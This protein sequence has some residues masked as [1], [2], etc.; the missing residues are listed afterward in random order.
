MYTCRILRIPFCVLS[1]LL[2]FCKL[3]DRHLIEVRGHIGS[4]FCLAYHA[5]HTLIV[6]CLF[7]NSV[8][9]VFTQ[10]T[11]VGTP[12]RT[13]STCKSSKIR[14]MLLQVNGC[15]TAK[16]KAIVLY[17][18]Q[19]AIDEADYS[20]GAPSVPRQLDHQSMRKTGY[21]DLIYSYSSYFNK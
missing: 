14:G 18:G 4:L 8:N 20:V 15:I 7:E 12:A 2:A 5:K 10:N 17:F 9:N 1:Q 3:R 11:P 16:I 19:S 13:I 6:C 21:L